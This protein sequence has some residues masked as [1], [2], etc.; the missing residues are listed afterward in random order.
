[1]TTQASNRPEAVA[2]VAIEPLDGVPNIRRAA[3]VLRLILALA[4]LVGGQLLATFDHLGVRS[5]ER[6]FVGVIVTIPVA[7]RDA[8]TSAVQFVELL[9]PLAC[10][11]GLAVRRRIAA[12]GQVLF[13]G[14]LGLGLGA[15]L[16]DIA[17]GRSHP[18]GWPELLT[19]RG[20]VF[21][22][23]FPPVAWLS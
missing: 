22:V 13:A 2:E 19:G 6:A 11:V 15:L 12:V 18:S 16:S 14:A 20:G 10:V 17:L 23:A 3:D 4:V 9:V 21:A 1:M 7:W 8:L 5:T